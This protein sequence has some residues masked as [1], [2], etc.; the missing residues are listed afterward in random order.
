MVYWI[1]GS[2]SSQDVDILAVVPSLGSIAENKV[3]VSQ[4][5]D[6]LKDKYSRELNVN[7]GILKDGVLVEVF[8]GT[9]DEVNNSVFDTYH[10]H[11]Q[12]FDLQIS[13]KIIRD[14]D[15]KTLRCL[16]VMTS[17]Y[18]RTSFRAEVKKAL[19]LGV[20]EKHRFLSELNISTITDLGPGK[21]MDFLDYLK[22][23]AFQMGQTHAL[24]SGVE[25]YTKESIGLTYPE[26]DPFLRRQ[27]GNL[28]AL[29]EFKKNFLSS[30]DPL[31]LKYQYEE[32][33]K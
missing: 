24:R 25:L 1:F 6:S 20:I 2:K 5:E 29:E 12:S 23:M 11:D 28:E 9:V 27:K 19:S 17:F 3:V 15:L 33:K 14:V 26:L 16:R 31:T 32:F 21:N 13:R 8:K 22:T 4:I 7:L 30:V 18:S 10:L